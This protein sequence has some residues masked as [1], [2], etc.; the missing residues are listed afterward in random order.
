MPMTSDEKWMA[1][2]WVSTLYP[3]LDFDDHACDYM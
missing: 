1:F 3:L 2:L